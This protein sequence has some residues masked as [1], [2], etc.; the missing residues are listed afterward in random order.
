MLTPAR[1]WSTALEGDHRPHVILFVG[2]N[3]TGKTTTI[4]KLAQRFVQGAGRSRWR[5]ATRSGPPRS[6]SCKI[7]AER[8]ECRGD[9]H[10]ASGADSAGLAY[11]ALRA[12]AREFREVC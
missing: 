1:K 11:E 6:S 7:W 12:G 2:V 8:T 4:G 3:G 9:R 5:P 10:A